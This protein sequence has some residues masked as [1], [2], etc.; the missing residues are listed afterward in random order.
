[1]SDSLD[2]SVNG[3]AHQVAAEPG[4]SL[5]T[6]LREEIGLTGAKNG[7]GEG[8]CGTCTVLVAGKPVRACVT[9][10]QEVSGPVTTIEG[11][12]GP[13]ALHPAQQGFA[14]LDAMQCGYCTP[15]MIVTA[16]A[17]LAE[18]PDPDEPLIRETMRG[19]VCRCGGYLRIT[20][21]VRRAAELTAGAAPA[22]TEPDADPAAAGSPARGGPPAASP[23]P[24]QAAP[25]AAGSA[26]GAS[27]PSAASAP[28]DHAK[29]VPWDLH[30]ASDRDYFAVLS[31]GLVSVLPPGNVPAAAG[32]RPPGP[33]AWDAN[34]GA[35]LHVGS[36]GAVT[37]FTGKVDVGQD[38]RTA[39][40]MLVAEEL[41]VP[42]DAV[43][44]VQG[45]TDVCPFD[46]GTFGSR[47]MPDAGGALRAAAAAARQALV[48]MAAASLEVDPAQLTAGDSVVRHAA[49]GRAAG[50][51]EL[52]NGLRRVVTASAETEVT[53]GQDWTVAGRPV[54]KRSAADAVTGAKLFPS[55][56][57]VP[58]RVPGMLYGKVLRPPAY[59]ATLRSAD[60]GGAE[61]IPGVTV[62]R[63]DSFVGVAAADPVTAG[64]ALAEIR[65]EWDR[66]TQ[67]SEPELDGYLRSHPV[68]ADGVWGPFRYEAGDVDQALGTAEV[69]LEQTYTAAYIAHV[70]IE[71]RVSLARWEDGRLTVVT[72]TQRPFGV[73]SELAKAMGITERDVRVIVPSSGT[74]FGGKH[75]GAVSAEAARLARATG[76]PVTVTWTRAEEFTWGYFRPAAVID[77]RSGADADGTLAAWEFTNINSGSPGIMAPYE[78]PGQRVE[79]RPARSPLPQGAYR[80]LAATANTF[81]RE[82]HMDEMAWRLGADPVEYRLRHL[83]D[84]RLAEVLRTAARRAGWEQ[85]R[86]ARTGSG[87][88]VGSGGSQQGMGIACGTEKGGRVATCAEVTVTPDGPRVDR[89]VTAYECGA[90]VNP[91]TVRAQVEGGTIMAIGGALFEAVHFSGGEIQNAALSRYRVPR[92]TDIPE[93]D[94]ELIDRPDLPPAG[95]GETPLVALAPALANAIFAASGDR[96]RSLPLLDHGPPAWRR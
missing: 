32:F 57:A 23:V 46:V 49:S 11:L 95:A 79:F 69:R 10:V 77:V 61:A 54:R 66:E 83:A 81:A 20:R 17:L 39:L 65:A 36:N 51:Q 33:G 62:V 9:P 12:A 29:R 40:C 22:D 31:D 34:G 75:A 16:T 7:C 86:D 63:E 8:A 53:G 21:A 92:F 42:Y 72:A 56:L 14:E 37:A 38:N 90:Q 70:P 47:S 3:A 55:D 91:R 76:R 18:H 41:G 64:R 89:I 88:G 58:S 19:N 4:R 6:A 71:P 84:E 27:V 74:G 85:W 28:G 48:S 44:L 35:W 30:D 52:V 60:V 80:G 78:I 1:M 24:A 96:I 50:Y 94:V 13:E 87:R 67:P 5:L 68:D 26:S 15:G 25:P 82:S 43:R 93:I 2:L 73:R 45:D 59:G